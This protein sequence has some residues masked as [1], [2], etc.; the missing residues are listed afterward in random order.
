V[1]IALASQQ[2]LEGVWL[3]PGIARY[4]FLSYI[5]FNSRG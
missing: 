4:T 2:A 1:G 5:L 3:L